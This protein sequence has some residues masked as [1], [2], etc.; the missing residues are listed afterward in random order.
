[1]ATLLEKCEQ[2]RFE[3]DTKL[4]PENLRFGVT[5]F[6]I[7]GMANFGIDTFDATA[8]PND[9]VLGRTAYARGE[10]IEGVV[11][12]VFDDYYLPLG[13]FQNVPTEDV[14]GIIWHTGVYSDVLLRNG[15]YVGATFPYSH[16]AD[17]IGLTSD[18]IVSG[19]TVL[20]VNGTGGA[21]G[22][23]YAP[24]HLSFAGSKKSTIVLDGN[25]LGIDFSHITDAS[26]MFAN[27]PNLTSVDLLQNIPSAN[28]TDMEG[29]FMNCPSLTQLDLHLLNWNSVTNTAHMF[30]GCQNLSW[31]NMYDF[32][33]SHIVNSEGMFDNCPSLQGINVGTQEA[34]DQ[35]L[36]I[37]PSLNVYVGA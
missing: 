17:A 15:T 12:E 13:E 28:I 10:K 9:V 27:C 33:G 2:I 26:Y 5:V 1:M 7:D 32:D 14:M 3:K 16:I 24:G 22:A 35:L 18:Q 21:G 29:M 34:M 36:A 25:A 4:L 37:N 11:P 23:K 6:G 19:N 31:I 20:G 8:T 30:D